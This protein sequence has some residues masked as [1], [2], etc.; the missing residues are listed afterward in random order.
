MHWTHCLIILAVF[1]RVESTPDLVAVACSRR[2]DLFF[3]NE[4]IKLNAYREILYNRLR[5]L[6]TRI[7]DGYLEWPSDESF[8]LANQRYATRNEFTTPEQRLNTKTGHTSAETMDSK[9]LQARRNRNR[10]IQ[11][12]ERGS[13]PRIDRRGLIRTLRAINSLT[14][15]PMTFSTERT[16][17]LLSKPFR[18][19][20]AFEAEPSDAVA[21]ENLDTFQ[22]ISSLSDRHGVHHRP[23]SRSPF[24]KPGLWEP[25]P[26][27][28]HNRDHAN[29]WYY[30]PFSVGADW[31]G[32]QASWGSH[33][34]VPA[35]GVGGTD[36]YSE[37]HFPSLGTVLNIPDDYD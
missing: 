7:P 23:R 1:W 34:A 18:D 3:C 9:K 24:V 19:D 21:Q 10:S 14:A 30:H 25:N 36:E 27:N 28:P 2:P 6:Q 8:F 32:G 5:T 12:S 15:D 29:K 20:Q 37:I 35:A 4:D 13:S 17:P 31:L 11:E 22:A 33:W 16:T 26:D